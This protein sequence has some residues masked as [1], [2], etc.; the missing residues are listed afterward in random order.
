MKRKICILTSVHSPFDIRIFHKQA[1]T[2]FSA[3]YDVTLIAAHSHTETVDGI[4]IIGLPKPNSRLKR[5]V[6]FPWK[7]LRTALGQ[8]AEFYH[9]HDP[10]LLPVG[11]VLKLFRKKIIYDVHENYTQSILGRRWIKPWLRKP[12]AWLTLCAEKFFCLFVDAIIPVTDTIAD[13]FPAGKTTQVRNYPLLSLSQPLPRQ[14]HRKREQL[15]YVGGL[16]RSRGI[17]EMVTAM[18]K[19]AGERD[20]RLL[21]LGRYEEPDLEPELKALSGYKKVDFGGWVTVNEVWQHM[22]AS[23]AGFVLFHPEPNHIDALPNKLFEYMSAGIP[24]IA[25]DFPLWTEIIRD[26]NCGLQVDPLD[27][28]E[29]ARAVNQLLSNPKERELMGRRGRQA[30]EE[31]YNWDREAEK[32]IDLYGRLRGS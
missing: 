23:I 15:I 5:V 4:K 8:G 17:R 21:I 14:S 7:I 19:I 32:L 12:L 13:K 6:S 28:E 20:I 29:I 30:V 1:K 18:D 3:G 16:R 9:F 22:S 25:S 24:V 10:E 11:A 27:P 26:N 2:L 31:K